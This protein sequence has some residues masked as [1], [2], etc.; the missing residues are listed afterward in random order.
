MNYRPIFDI[1]TVR[2]PQHYA[3]GHDTTTV[4]PEFSHQRPR[5]GR[6]ALTPRPDQKPTR[7]RIPT[8]RNPTAEPIPIPR[9]GSI[10][11]SAG[12]AS[13]QASTVVRIAS[14]SYDES[15]TRV[16]VMRRV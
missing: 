2:T 5:S 10:Y 14:F 9:T 15:V 16:R 8:M 13:A 3:A 11:A 12:T 6:A 4:I 1:I 7:R